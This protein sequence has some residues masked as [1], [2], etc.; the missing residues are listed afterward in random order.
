[1]GNLAPFCAR[2]LN[3]RK[4]RWLIQAHKGPSNPGTTLA[5]QP[6]SA[7]CVEPW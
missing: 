2:S 6:V 7:K 1:M 5:T 4:G 3:Y